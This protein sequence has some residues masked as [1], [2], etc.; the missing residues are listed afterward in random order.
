MDPTK[1]F[2]EYF[3][4]EA[5]ETGVLKEIDAFTAAEHC[6]HNAEPLLSP[7]N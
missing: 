4:V 5:A 2:L 6:V 3:S 7:S 1:P